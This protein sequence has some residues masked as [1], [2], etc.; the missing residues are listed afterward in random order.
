MK[1]IEMAY[2]TW[3]G[4]S[5]A[6][7]LIDMGYFTIIALYFCKYYVDTWRK[8]NDTTNIITK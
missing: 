3:R 2:E 4:T 7:R 1:D 6:E 8:K 5:E